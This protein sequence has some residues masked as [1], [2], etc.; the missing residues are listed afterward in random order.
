VNSKHE[1]T[2]FKFHSMT[3]IKLFTTVLGCFITLVG[4]AGC[5][6]K[7]DVSLKDAFKNKFHIGV[8][9]NKSQ[10]LGEDIKANQNVLS[11][12]NS[13]VTENCM[14]SGE[15]QVVEGKFDFTLADKF[16][17]FGLKNNMFLIGHTLIWH[18]QTPR[19]FFVDKEGQTVSREV[20]IERMRTHIYT[21]VKRYKGKVK[22]WDV[23]N[24]AI[25][26][27]GSWRNSKF[28]QV[29][30]EDFV[31]LAFQFAHEADPD[32]EL[33]YNDYSMALE[34]RRNGV[35]TLVKSLQ[36]QG[37]KITGIGM[38][39]HISMDSPSITDFEKS[40]VAFSELGLKVMITELDLSALPSPW[41]NMGANISDVVAYQEK[42]N[43]YTKGLPVEVETAWENR[44]LDFFKLFLKHKDKISRVT[45]WGVSDATS[46]KNDFPVKGR[47][48][49]PL[50][51]DRDNQPKPIL[52]KIIKIA[53]EAGN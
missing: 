36:K 13:I 15:L 2:Y 45:L 52:K 1:I 29:L 21:V 26:D 32:A 51:F 42:M 23:V 35:L 31:K 34:G 14:K 7:E 37:V 3:K 16:V 30:G 47:T 22:G 50:L 4:F 28:Y 8:A 39:G 53:N 5:K 12:F 40:I 49:Y 44:F 19:W 27:N 20:L 24:E 46:W 9:L 11:Q 25:E 18:S 41:S 6:H 38:Q 33:Y 17:D 43:P 10:I 48:D